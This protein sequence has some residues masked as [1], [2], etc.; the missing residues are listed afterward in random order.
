MQDY[1][2]EDLAALKVAV[3]VLTAI[4]EQ[5]SFCSF[6]SSGSADYRS[7][8]FWRLGSRSGTAWKHGRLDRCIRSKYIRGVPGAKPRPQRALETTASMC[9]PS[10]LAHPYHWRPI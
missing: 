10:L 2:V 7:S 6:G 1:V 5:S 8:R 9:A 4:I 3:R